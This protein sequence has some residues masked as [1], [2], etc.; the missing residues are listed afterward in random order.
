MESRFGTWFAWRR[1]EFLE[2]KIDGSDSN[3]LTGTATR[4]SE[5]GEEG[6]ALGIA[7]FTGGFDGGL[8]CG[9]VEGGDAVPVVS[10]S[11]FVSRIRAGTSFSGRRPGGEK[12]IDGRAEVEADGSEGGAGPSEEA[13]VT[14]G[15]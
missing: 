3:S 14:C 11:R 15:R 6:G 4:G 10:R 2:K 12:G 7:G 8:D 1:K 13:T 9:T 5:G